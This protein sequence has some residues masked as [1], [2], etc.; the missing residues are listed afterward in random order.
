MNSVETANE[1]TELLAGQNIKEQLS[2]AQ[3]VE[4]ATSRNEAILTADGAVRALTGKY[5]GRSPRDKF[6]V[7]E[8]CSKDKIDWGKVNQSIS[9]EVFDNLYKKVVDYLKAKEEV[10]VFKG[11]AGADEDSRLSIRV[12]NEYAW[13]NLFA[14]QLFIRPSQEELA[15]HV[16]DFT[17]VSAPTFKADPAVDGT[18]SE[19]FIIVSLEKKI[20]LIGGTEYAGEMKKSI[21]GIMNYLLP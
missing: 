17:I 14:H 13:H 5:T 9:S 19:T 11:F 7:E 3:L 8:D 4:K 6:F 12:V 21:F 1:L 2:V 20:V 10:F 16:A 18:T 15:N